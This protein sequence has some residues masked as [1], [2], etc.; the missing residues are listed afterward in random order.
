MQIPRRGQ[1]PLLLHPE[2]DLKQ[3]GL[4]PPLHTLCALTSFSLPA[5]VSIPL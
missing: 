3:A 1:G 2:H 5:K 4:Y